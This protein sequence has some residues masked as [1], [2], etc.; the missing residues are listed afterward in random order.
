ME[1]SHAERAQGGCVS[2]NASPGEGKWGEE[3]KSRVEEDFRIG[4]YVSHPWPATF[5]AFLLVFLQLGEVALLTLGVWLVAVSF[6]SFFSCKLLQGQRIAFQED[7]S[8]RGDVNY[9][10][11]FVNSSNDSR[12]V[13]LNSKGVDF[14]FKPMALWLVL[15]PPAKRW[16]FFSLHS[17]GTSPAFNE[18]SPDFLKYYFDSERLNNSGMFWYISDEITVV[19]SAFIALI[20]KAIEN[21]L[22]K[23]LIWT[24]LSYNLFFFF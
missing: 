2:H 9:N 19:I 12:A 13:Q 17:S 23:L 14:S 3:R 21:G 10:Q 5:N 22:L 18:C 16:I 6:F 24:R 8:R 7:V 20:G 4:W 1:H 15:Q 11:Y